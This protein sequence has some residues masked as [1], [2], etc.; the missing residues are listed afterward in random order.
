MSDII[1]PV[2]HEPKAMHGYLSTPNERTQRPAVIVLHELF[3]VS[4][5]IRGVVDRLATR[6]YLTVAPEMYYRDTEPGEWFERNDVG[7]KRGFECLNR[8][9]RNAVVSIVESTMHV[10]KE[11]HNVDASRI[12]LLGFSAGGHMAFY[13]AS[14]L[15]ITATAVL[16]PGWLT[17]GD[18]TIAQGTPT[19][20]RAA[21]LAKRGGKLLFAVGGKDAI[22]GPDQVAEIRAKLDA[23]KVDAEVVVYPNAEHAF[24]WEGTPAFEPSSAE[25]GWR[26][27]EAFFGRTLAP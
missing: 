7:R 9:D 1:I 13:A 5:D 20:D 21:L 10:S 4:P 11:R 15:P 16:Y 3:G 25:D 26:R 14:A 6:G 18:V 2:G 22:I 27:I 8:L 17:G 24:F 23:A 19:I 12:G